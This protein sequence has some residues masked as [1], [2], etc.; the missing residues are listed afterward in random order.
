MKRLMHRGTTR[1]AEETVLSPHPWH[2]A[3]LASDD[4]LR[5]G[6][7]QTVGPLM[8][9]GANVPE[10]YLAAVISTARMCT[11]KQQGS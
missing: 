9:F 5:A 3:G 11:T 2:G 8:S 7:R 1:R 6:V 10:V 4:L